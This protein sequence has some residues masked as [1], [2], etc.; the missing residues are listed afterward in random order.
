ME[1]VKSA[2]IRVVSG[3][4]SILMVRVFYGFV[5]SASKNFDTREKFSA[6]RQSQD[7]TIGIDYRK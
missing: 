5:V 3:D 6:A 2:I 4:S 1:N 7:L